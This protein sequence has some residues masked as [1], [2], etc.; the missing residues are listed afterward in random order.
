MNQ[1]TPAQFAEVIESPDV[2][3]LDVR[4]A[5]EFEAAHIDGAILIDIQSPEY[6][7]R[8]AELDKTARYAVYCRSGNRSTYACQDLQD[9]GVTR[10]EHLQNGIIEWMDRNYPV[11]QG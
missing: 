2:V 5:H 10:I 11:N 1:C 3:I 9:L 8:I 7:S 4:T 6:A